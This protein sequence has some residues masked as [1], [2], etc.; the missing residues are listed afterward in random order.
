MPYASTF[1]AENVWKRSCGIDIDDVTIPS[2]SPEDQFNLLCVHSAKHGW[3]RLYMLVDIA[4]MMAN[5]DINW[6]KV[7][8]R[9]KRIKAERMLGLGVLL[10]HKLF[11]IPDSPIFTC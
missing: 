10:A 3:H 5:V 4:N 7:S 6:Q 2:L 11:K 8:I 9:A 1:D